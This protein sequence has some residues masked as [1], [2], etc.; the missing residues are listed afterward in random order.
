MKKFFPIIASIFATIIFFAATRLNMRLLFD[1]NNHLMISDI[2][3]AFTPAVVVLVAYLLSFIFTRNFL[4][5]LIIS[6]KV[7]SWTALLTLVIAFLGFSY[8]ESPAFRHIFYTWLLVGNLSSTLFYLI[9]GS[10]T[11]GL[12]YFLLKGNAIALTS[13]Y[14]DNAEQSAAV[15]N[16][17]KFVVYILAALIAVIFCWAA[18]QDIP[19]VLLIS[20]LLVF[21]YRL[22]YRKRIYK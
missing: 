12:F 9:W 21:Y 8:P 18:F 6:A 20:I 15:G 19:I 5:S 7:L 16:K 10:I 4:Q 11:W 2:V 1:G 3:V 14:I 22:V 17:T 13:S